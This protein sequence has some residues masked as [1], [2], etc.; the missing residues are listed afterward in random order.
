MLLLLF[1]AR[2]RQV[3][4]GNEGNA[5]LDPMLVPFGGCRGSRSALPNITVQQRT[6][7]LQVLEGVSPA[8]ERGCKVLGLE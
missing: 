7:R 1:F 8:Y 3:R 2:D 5:R 4:G 6:G